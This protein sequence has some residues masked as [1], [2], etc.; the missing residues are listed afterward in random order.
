MKFEEFIKY[1]EDFDG[2]TK[3][4]NDTYKLKFSSDY[5]LTITS[6][7]IIAHNEY[8]G[9]TRVVTD[10]VD[11]EEA[12]DTITNISS[13]EHEVTLYIYERDCKYD[14]Y[15]LK[16]DNQQQRFCWYDEDDPYF[17]AKTEGNYI[18]LELYDTIYDDD[19][20]DEDEDDDKEVGYDNEWYANIPL[21]I[22][23]KELANTII[24]SAYCNLRDKGHYTARLDR[25]DINYE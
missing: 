12:L 7:D 19:E 14:D 2:F 15:P 5:F 24:Y 17:I 22:N 1:Y 18:Y 8:A 13:G 20:D 4:D 11:Y 10:Y 6:K 21:L 16:R 25:S 9:D 23:N 3:E